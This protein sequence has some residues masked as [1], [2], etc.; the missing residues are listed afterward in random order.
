MDISEAETPGMRRF[1][2]LC[3][4]VLGACIPI[5]FDVLKEML[6]YVPLAPVQR[7]WAERMLLPAVLVG[8]LGM[9]VVAFRV[10]R[11]SKRPGLPTTFAMVAYIWGIV[12][13]GRF[14]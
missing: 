10:V 9:M 3:T 7:T 13:R 2:V 8:L 14:S 6:V 11:Y 12:L 4:L 5:I 1:K